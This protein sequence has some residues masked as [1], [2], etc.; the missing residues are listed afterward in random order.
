MN[1]N[2]SVNKF[3]DR[4]FWLIIITQVPIYV[5]WILMIIYDS[6]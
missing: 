1:R 6:I 3:I 2:K 4:I 5:V